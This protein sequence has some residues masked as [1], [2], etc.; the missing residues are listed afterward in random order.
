[1]NRLKIT[2]RNAALLTL[3]SIVPQIMTAQSLELPGRDSSKL[4]TSP[5]GFVGQ[6]VGTHDVHI[7]YGR[8]YVK[9][10]EVF[11]ELQPFGKVWRA[12]ANEATAILIPADAKIEGEDL[13]AGVYSFF[14]IPGEKEWTIIFNDQGKIWGTGHDAA[15]DVLRVTVD[16]REAPHSE[17]LSYR[18]ED[19]TA[20]SATIVLHW[21]TTEIPFAITFG[22]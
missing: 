6:T 11:G 21:A 10:R 2:F 16:S 22:E 18:F 5:S 9:G 7:S 13:A 4:R 20:N 15:N 19:V 12:G 3:I 8:P 14:T 1:M 17:M